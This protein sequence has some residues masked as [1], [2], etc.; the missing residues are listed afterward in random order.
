MALELQRF[1]ERAAM[2][3]IRASV[4]SGE[5]AIVFSAAFDKVL[6]ANAEG[7]K[8]F[9]G[10]TVTELLESPISTGHSFIR[11]VHDAAE[12][13]E[14]EQPIVRGFRISRGLTA[15][16]IQC[17]LRTLEIDEDQ[18]AILLGCSPPD[19][20]G[21]RREHERA[22][23]VVDGLAGLAWASAIVDGSGLPLAV[24]DRYAQI[25]IDD[26][27]MAGWLDAANLAGAGLHSVPSSAELEHP[28]LLLRL[29][30]HPQRFL[31]GIGERETP[32]E[33]SAELPQGDDN[34][35]SVL[36]GAAVGTAVAGAAGGAVFAADADSD[37]LSDDELRDG[38]LAERD[39]IT[40]PN[41]AEEPSAEL[42]DDDRPDDSNELSGGFEAG[43]EEPDPT[44]QP[45]VAEAVSETVEEPDAAEFPGG[46]H[47]AIPDEADLGPDEDEPGASEPDTLQSDEDVPELEPAASETTEHG[48]AESETADLSGRHDDQIAQKS[49]DDAELEEVATESEPAD[50]E[51]GAAEPVIAAE[52]AEAEPSADEAAD[53]AADQTVEKRPKP[54]RSLLE[55]WFMRRGDEEPAD[56]EP[57]ENDAP[58][59]QEVPEQAGAEDQ[60][61]LS[62]QSEAV[63]TA[64]SETKTGDDASEDEGEDDG[65]GLA[66]AGAIAGAGLIATTVALAPSSDDDNEAQGDA[67]QHDDMAG[68]EDEPVTSEADTAS[69]AGAGAGETHADDEAET[70]GASAFAFSES[71]E[72]VR[73]AWTT[74][75]NQT[76][77]SVSPEL[78]EAVGPNAADIIGRK[79]QDVAKVFGFDETGE[80]AGLL[81]NR[82]TW[83]GKSVLWPVQ[84][85]DL[86]VPVDLAALPAFSASRAFE[87]FRGFGIIRTADAVV[88]PDEIGLAL[89]GG[90]SS[91][92]EGS[93]LGDEQPVDGED[94]AYTIEQRV[95]AGSPDDSDGEDDDSQTADSG[96]AP[97]AG[98]VGAGAALAGIAA[99]NVVDLTSRKRAS[100][101]ADEAEPEEAQVDPYAPLS[102]R[103]A[104]AFEEIGRRLG[105]DGDERAAQPV[106]GSDRA[107]SAQAA[108]LE[109]LPVPVIV[110]RNGHS[111]FAN[112]ELLTQTGY[113]DTAA[114]DAA[115]G[116]E[117]LFGDAAISEG[118]D[119]AQKLRCQDGSE[120]EVS[121]LLKSVPWDGGKALLLTFRPTALPPSQVREAIDI[122]RVSELQNILDTAS[123]GI[124]VISGDGLIESVNAP[125]EQLFGV[126]FDDAARRHVT[127]LFAQESH[128]E[129]ND[130]VAQAADPARSATTNQG[131]EAIGKHSDGA[132]IPLFVTLGRMGEDNKLCAVLRNITQWKKA[133]EDLVS[134]RKAAETASEHKSDFLARVSHEIRTPLN[135]IIGF[136]DVMI[137]ERFGPVENERYREYLR[138]INRSGI[139]ILDLINDLL[140]ISKIEAGKMELSF[141]AV[142]LSQIVAETV[143]LLQPQA[144]VERI[145]IRTSL[146]RAVPRVVADARTIRQI[147][148]NLVSNAIKF[149][150]SNGQVI[151]ST[152][153]ET[154]GEVVLN[155]RDTG[156]GMSEAELEQ[157]LKPFS[158]IGTV[159][160]RRGQGTG[161]GLPLTKAL[162][163]ANRAHFDLESVPGEGTIALVQ[164]PTQR[165]LAD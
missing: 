130:Y 51:D 145:L 146:S 150:A 34:S 43:E 48:A 65:N 104:M 151:I 162:V 38:E 32:T 127:E 126:R 101:G 87:G 94:P 57:A 141:E 73:F 17:E 138:D 79:W 164:F 84:G 62:E 75:D 1:F 66:A 154:N 92:S 108:I 37:G 41:A 52:A 120:I 54:I 3:P 81:E 113:A 129:V 71:A 58:E 93:E 149:T 76:F 106:P 14:D 152:V 89:A 114:I 134:A 105:S 2:A 100:S 5:A 103:E 60:P 53:Q 125:A 160:D 46:M 144:N 18:S 123:D 30:E 74:D 55:R 163:E 110:Y 135:A 39:D 24:S 49:A 69:D 83:S 56:E 36:A 44:E 10:G 45:N 70:E 22:Q 19:G 140:D 4:L 161:L 157:A 122:A 26:E 95:M 40:E 21:H 9:G 25:E 86:T 136:S 27:T 68:H 88:D 63:G 31:I 67:A 91:D 158:Q 50:E 124:V 13:I 47:Q 29:S 7:A 12:Q 23:N 59:Q 96:L 143:A 121:P 128:K 159:D 8:L 119:S 148:L 102:G 147:V 61:E 16:F 28:A 132:L 116:V 107:S 78:A 82:D 90:Y 139:H 99:S 15:Q 98:A 35:M 97:V 165:V 131:R 80:I 33:I 72:P 155:I 109:Q 6:W 11:Q 42:P 64:E 112:K 115:G 133:E 111:L 156:K 137:E 142:D 20:P 117:A 153:Y 118:D 85:A 77:V